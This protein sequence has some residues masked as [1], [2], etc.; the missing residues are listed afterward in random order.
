MFN[1]FKFFKK[2][3]VKVVPEIDITWYTF[4]TVKEAMDKIAS[5]KNPETYEAVR[6]RQ[7]G[8]LATGWVIRKIK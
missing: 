8:R 2:K 7:K 3:E 1:I 6:N 4:H 5:L